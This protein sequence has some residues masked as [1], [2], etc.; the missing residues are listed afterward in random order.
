M[1]VC[2]ACTCLCVLHVYTVCMWCVYATCL[3]VCAEY[4]LHVCVL[5]VCVCMLHVCAACMW[6]MGVACVCATCVYGTWVLHAC[7]HV[8]KCV[9]MFFCA[10]VYLRGWPRV[11]SSVTHLFS[12]WDRLSQWTQNL[13]ITMFDQTRSPLL[14]RCLPPC[15]PFNSV[16]SS[17]TFKSFINNFQLVLPMCVLV[18]WCHPLGHGQLRRGTI[19]F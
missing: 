19:F 4:V 6:Y 16:S 7:V 10:C 8:C 5:H 13:V 17:Y 2:A 11:S 12:V 1:Y 18:P 9:F 3:C 14:P 15:Y